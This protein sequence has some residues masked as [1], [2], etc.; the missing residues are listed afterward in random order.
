[1]L[2]ADPL[3]DGIPRPGPPCPAQTGGQAMK[4]LR[5]MTEGELSDV[6]VRAARVSSRCL[7]RGRGPGG[8]PMYVLLVFDDPEVAQYISSCQRS[9]II[10][11]MRETADRLELKQ[12]VARP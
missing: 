2:L 4:T 12:D 8:R 10:K 7:P 3:A 1:M 9:D 11:C 6:M 5:D